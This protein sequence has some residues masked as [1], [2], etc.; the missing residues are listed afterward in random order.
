LWHLVRQAYPRSR[1]VLREQG[2]ESDHVTPS[3]QDETWAITHATLLGDGWR[4]AG[5]AAGIIDEHGNYIACNDALCD[6]T[7]YTRQE[8]L[9]MRAGEQLAAD[10]AARA[11]YVE[12]RRRE[13]L[14]G[15]GQLRR[16]DGGVVSVNYWLIPTQV[17]GLPYSV[18]LM[19]AEGNGPNLAERPAT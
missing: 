4:A 16:R 8:L 1:H 13:R 3:A 17:V 18:A 7:G 11:N 12:A 14:W 2:L 9:A 6:L 10:D 15:F 5:V 19:W